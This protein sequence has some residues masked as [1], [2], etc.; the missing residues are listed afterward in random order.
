MPSTAP[1][2]RFE[3][4]PMKRFATFILLLAAASTSADTTYRP[5]LTQAKFPR[6]SGHGFSAGTAISKTVPILESNL[7]S[8]ASSAQR[9]RTPGLLMDYDAGGYSNGAA[10]TPTP[11]VN[12]VSG[13][14]WTWESENCVFAYEGQIRLP[15]G[16][17]LVPYTRFDD[18]A[19]MTIGGHLLAFQGVQNGDKGGSSVEPLVLEPHA[20]P[21]DRWVPVN[22][23][24]YDWSGNKRPA[25]GLYA[26]QFNTNGVTGDLTNAGV[27][28]R[29]ADP[30]DMSFLRTR[31][32]ETFLH[33]E[34]AV[35]DGDDLLVSVSFHDVPATAAFSAWSGPVDGGTDMSGPWVTHVDL[36]T[37]A[38]GDSPEAVFRIPGGAISRYVRFRLFHLSE[39]G[40]LRRLIMI[41]AVDKIYAP[42]I[43]QIFGS[44]ELM[45]HNKGIGSV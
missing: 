42:Y 38:A 3:T 44:P 45:E 9:D 4:T 43:S 1:I 39:T 13:T 25:A 41:P 17:T 23:W 40:T 24:I 37:I 15:A 20:F 36:G 27:W 21:S 12:P 5:G 19:A 29:F 22:A 30:G 10:T 18:G 31:T 7:L 26:I 32:D 35:A 8:N 2:P 16:T 28:K 6:G 33:V 34:S 11:A 14:T